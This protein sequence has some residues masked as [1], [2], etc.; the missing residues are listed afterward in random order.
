MIII[1]D[2]KYDE[3]RRYVERV[4][5][6]DRFYSEQ[7]D[8]VNEALS[9]QFIHHVENSIGVK[10][11]EAQV[12]I[13]SELDKSDLMFTFVSLSFKSDKRHLAM[14]DD[15]ERIIEV[16]LNFG[17]PFSV[18]VASTIPRVETYG[19]VPTTLPYDVVRYY[20]WGYDLERN[21]QVWKEK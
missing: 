8:S 2:K 21:V 19:E 13:R 17:P 9:D 20:P 3:L 11:Q 12:E 14:W 5:I 15:I 4:R 1:D 6:E 18:Q 7:K 10:L 16:P